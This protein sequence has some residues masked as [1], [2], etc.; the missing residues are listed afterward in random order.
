MSFLSALFS[1]AKP[2]TL[3]SNSLDLVTR[4]AGLASR[5]DEIDPLLDK[6]RS[7]T[8]RL[9]PDQTPSAKDTQAL[10]AVYLQLEDYLGTRETIRSFTKQQLRAR[11]SK[12]LQQQLTD[13]ETHSKGS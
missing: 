3:I 2:S 11:L 10:F 4:T 9:G 6:V 12:E 5:P 7:I 13:F 8:A 1:P